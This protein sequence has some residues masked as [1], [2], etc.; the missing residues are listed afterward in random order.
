MSNEI[1][2]QEQ[3]Y[4]Q[5][6]SQM[7]FHPTIVENKT[8]V[9]GYMKI[10]FSKIASLGTSFEPIVSTAKSLFSNTETGLYKVTLPKGTHL[11]EFKNGAGNLG[12]VL[13]SHN[14][15]SG[16]AVL[17]PVD[18]VVSL[19]PTTMF[20]AATLAT[21]E[22]KLDAIQETQ[23]EMMDF[24]ERKEMAEQRGNLIF[25]SDV[26]NN[27][28]YNWDNDM[29]KNNSHIKVLDIRQSSE[30]KIAFYRDQVTARLKKRNMFHSDRDAS[31]Y[32]QGVQDTFKE[33]QLALYLCG[34]SSFLDIMLLDNHSSD[35]LDGVTKKLEDYSLQYRE[36]YTESYNQVESY[37][38]SSVESTVLKGLS[39]ASKATGKY[40]SKMSFASKRNLDETL[41]KAGN[42]LEQF[43]TERT[44]QSMLQMVDHQSSCVKPFVENINAVNKINNNDLNVVFDE[45]AL[46]IGTEE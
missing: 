40:I 31:K 6:L 39:F 3:S 45:E 7:E 2:K 15:I 35:F 29:Y 43:K 14:K 26:M 19:N 24:L 30:Q 13:D 20:M 10:P 12:T 23:Q 27:F 5:N 42:K 44:D 46:Y 41:I 21:V 8:Q 16:Q 1:I 4:L 28:K 32:L 34:F 33:Y 25:L 18:K 37:L 11:A 38:K 36:L 17:N 9:S 22:K